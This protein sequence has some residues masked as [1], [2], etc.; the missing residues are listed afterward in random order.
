MQLANY[1][2]FV[3]SVSQEKMSKDIMSL[4]VSSRWGVWSG[5]VHLLFSYSARSRPIASSKFQV[6]VPSFT[7]LSMQPAIE[8]LVVSAWTEYPLLQLNNSGTKP[9]CVRGD[10]RKT[11]TI[12]DTRITNP[13]SAASFGE[14]RL[15]ACTGEAICTMGEALRACLSL[16]AW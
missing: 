14:S 9:S 15:V 7:V 5:Y 10:A 12:V 3:K 8:G 6:E 16:A 1:N 13:H 4:L 11:I 2:F